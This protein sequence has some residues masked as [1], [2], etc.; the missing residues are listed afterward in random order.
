MCVADRF[1]VSAGKALDTNVQVDPWK[2]L[3]SDSA[4]FPFPL[5]SVIEIRVLG[6]M[7]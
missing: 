3:R 6:Y 5:D 4:S 7:R 1:D 2:V